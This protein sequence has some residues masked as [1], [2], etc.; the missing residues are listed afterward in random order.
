MLVSLRLVRNINLTPFASH[1]F[2]QLSRSSKYLGMDFFPRYFDDLESY[3][4]DERQKFE[5]FLT[6]QSETSILI[7]GTNTNI[8]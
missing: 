5:M 6:K 2:D 1:L 7:A 4:G 8:V 3:Q